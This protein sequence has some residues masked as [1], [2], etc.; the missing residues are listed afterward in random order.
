MKLVRV[1]REMPGAKVGH[2][3]SS[4]DVEVDKDGRHEYRSTESLVEDGWLEYVKEEQTLEEKFRDVSVNPFNDLVMDFGRNHALP[5]K[6]V[7][8]LADI[9]RKHFLEAFD[10]SGTDYICTLP[11]ESP[12][13]Y[14][15]KYLENA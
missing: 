11:D 2:I 9:A 15:R 13:K 14:I 3:I 7:E 5:I 4:V 12:T 1:L 6:L 8:N 10:K